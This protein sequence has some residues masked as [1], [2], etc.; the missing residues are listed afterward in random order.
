LHPLKKAAIF[1]GWLL[2]PLVLIAYALSV[3]NSDTGTGWLLLRIPPSAL[4]TTFFAPTAHPERWATVPP[5]NRLGFS[6]YW[7]QTFKMLSWAYTTFPLSDSSKSSSQNDLELDDKLEEKYRVGH[8]KAR[9]L[10]FMAQPSGRAAAIISIEGA[11]APSGPDILARL[12]A[13]PNIGWQARPV[14]MGLMWQH[15]AL[16][17]SLLWL[18]GWLHISTETGPL[19]EL[20][21]STRFVEIKRE[22]PG[23]ASHGLMLYTEQWPLGKS[24]LTTL[25]YPLTRVQ[26]RVRALALIPVAIN[27]N[28]WRYAGSG[29]PTFKRMRWPIPNS[30]AVF[31]GNELND[32]ANR[33]KIESAAGWAVRLASVPGF[34][35]GPTDSLS[36]LREQIVRQ[37]T[38]LTLRLG[39][40][41][42]GMPPSLN[43]A[44]VLHD[45]A[46]ISESVASLPGNVPIALKEGKTVWRATLALPKRLFGLQDPAFDTCYWWA[47]ASS[48]LLSTHLPE[49]IQTKPGAE[50]LAPDAD[51]SLNFLPAAIWNRPEARRQQGGMPWLASLRA[52]LPITM[53]G[54]AGLH[55][56]QRGTRIDFNLALD[57]NNPLIQKKSTPY[58]QRTFSLKGPVRQVGYVSNSELTW[59]IAGTQIAFM[60]PGKSP[61]ATFPFATITS[62]DTLLT[63][64]FRV[65]L[66]YK[67]KSTLNNS[68]TDN[69][70]SAKSE[71]RIWF[72]T[73]S[74]SGIAGYDSAQ[75]K[76]ALTMRWPWGATLPS[77]TTFSILPDTLTL[78]TLQGD[79]LWI[80][81][82]PGYGLGTWK[83]YPLPQK[84]LKSQPTVLPLPS[85]VG[86]QN[87]TLNAQL[88]LSADTSTWLFS[89]GAWQ[90]LN[91]SIPNGSS[92]V[93]LNTK[94]SGLHLL[95]LTDKGLLLSS[96]PSNRASLLLKKQLYQ[97]D[98]DTHFQ[99]LLQSNSHPVWANQTTTPHTSDA[100]ILR[101]SSFSAAWYNLEG[102]K[103][104]EIVLA[105]PAKSSFSWHNLNNAGTTVPLKKL[106]A[107][108][109][110]DSLQLYNVLALP[111]FKKSMPAKGLFLLSPAAQNR[112]WLGT[113]QQE[114]FM[115]QC[116]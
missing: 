116:F 90:E 18:D 81:G 22:L 79:K 60:R 6:T 64:P 32:K 74:S 85:W 94:A 93:A 56:R 39:A 100:V 98:R 21:A 7:S 73:A 108:Q 104:G 28:G 36:P 41:Q 105:N 97:P 8:T 4:G 34:I 83:S 13:M 35:A 71:N 37:T 23:T 40:A 43:L 16:P 106:L 82:W 53:A 95:N 75:N 44:W 51:L 47:G 77:N 70:S 92:Q 55:I 86:K 19:E 25:Y 103:L 65:S 78:L 84:A 12:T 113:C 88:I 112:I 49:L 63:A 5:F 29:I 72:V 20:A 24:A 114:K 107:C 87:A 58:E 42:P 59:L 110:N 14:G 102:D 17:Y 38:S 11:A 10:T 33:A 48:I 80:W 96:E 76:L 57:P 2:L 91:F 115:W 30:M 54:F 15:P 89:K 46:T 1:I 67:G 31:S 69:I 99:L 27:A 68:K 50:T 111:V 101:R 109:S 3:T 9:A 62:N 26:A 66:V 61:L 45:V 52:T